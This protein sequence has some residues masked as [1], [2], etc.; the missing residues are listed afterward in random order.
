[1]IFDLQKA[2]MWKRISAFLC[3]F[4]LFAIVAVG[5]ALLLS[6]VLGVDAQQ[7][8]MISICAQYTEE[9]GLSDFM[10][11]DEL[12]DS[13]SLT[14]TEERYNAF[15]EE[16]QAIF[17]EAAT[18]LYSNGDYLYA[19][20]MVNQLILIVVTFSVLIAQLLLEF[21]VPLLFKNGQTLGK[22]VFGVA[23][24]RMDGVK[25]SPVILL[26]RTV[27]GKYTIETMIPVF[28]LLSVVL[29]TASI[30]TIV[31]LFLLIIAQIVLLIFTQA[32]TPLHDMLAGT[33]TVD[34]ASQLI[35]DTPEELLE[36]KKKLHADSVAEKGSNS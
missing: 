2:S 25:I 5:F 27:L 14:I 19:Y 29:G 23:V 24:M 18:A 10:T 16:Q 4:I 17:Q 33:V 11:E 21:V 6:T 12:K 32:N 35:F 15:T 34:F 13:L 3:D 9:Y 31:L 26:I 20:E 28:V 1:M 8:K 30:V 36:Y 22:K 7:N